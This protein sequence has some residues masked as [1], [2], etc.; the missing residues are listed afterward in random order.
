MKIK[1]TFREETKLVSFLNSYQSLVDY[2]NKVLLTGQDFQLLNL[3]YV[4]ID[5]DDEEITISNEEDFSEAVNTMKDRT[6]LKI[7][8]QELPRS[9]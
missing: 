1:I 6:Y 5:E 9:A 7:T 8:I 3:K 2:T 4:Y